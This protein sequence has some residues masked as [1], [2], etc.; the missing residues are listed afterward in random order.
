MRASVN[1]IHYLKHAW[2]KTASIWGKVTI[3]LF[4]IFVWFNIIWSVTSLFAPGTMGFS[5]TKDRYSESENI[6]FAMAVRFLS[7][8]CLGFFLY[9]DRGGIAVW[10]VSLVFI[11]CAVY[12]GIAFHSLNALWEANEDVAESCSQDKNT[13][14][15]SSLGYLLWAA[16]TVVTAL[17]ED[18]AKESVAAAQS[19]NNGESSPLVA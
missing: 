3:V 4:Y 15:K 10:N 13:A 16:L 12:S 8:F 18:N 6:L 5:C 2:E 1:P 7:I 17:L 11:V 9:A 14:F 19:G